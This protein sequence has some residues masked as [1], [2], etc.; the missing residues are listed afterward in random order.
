MI[1]P[2]ASNPNKASFFKCTGPG[3]C[4]RIV[5]WFNNH[6]PAFCWI[7]R[8][9]WQFR[10]SQIPIADIHSQHLLSSF[11]QTRRSQPRQVAKLD[12]KKHIYYGHVYFSNLN[13]PWVVPF[14]YVAITN[15]A[16]SIW[17]FN[18]R[19]SALTKFTVK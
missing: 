14:V 16:F 17:L 10:H 3:F 5:S 9:E 8:L 7:A 19:S 6:S 18:I 12:K 15:V 13:K 11:L 1:L 4:R 2:V